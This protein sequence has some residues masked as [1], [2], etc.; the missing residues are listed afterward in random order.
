MEAQI[1]S[2]RQKQNLNSF[3]TEDKA[4]MA[5]IYSV[6]SKH[7]ATKRFGVTLLQEDFKIEPDEILI[8]T[9]DMRTRV[10]KI[11]PYKFEDVKH[12]EAIET[13]W[14]LDTGNAVMNCKCVTGGPEGGHQHYSRG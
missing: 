5:D 7:N 2:T 6:L 8:E 11:M 14:R 4:L 9:T 3:V 13:S 12:L 10:Q 1:F